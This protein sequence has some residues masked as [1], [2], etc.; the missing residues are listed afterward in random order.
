M[1]VKEAIEYVNNKIKDLEDDLSHEK[2]VERNELQARKISWEID[3]WDNILEILKG[4][5]EDH[6]NN[7][8]F[9]IYDKISVLEDEL[10]DEED[11]A[12]VSSMK[13]DLNK[14][15][16]ILELLRK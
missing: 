5:K 6:L 4:N 13:Y 14:Y 7:S 1:N 8:K 11:R 10:T 3:E 2:Y 12:R 15:N 9:F 16:N